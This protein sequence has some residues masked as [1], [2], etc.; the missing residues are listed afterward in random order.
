MKALE[1]LR[2]LN[3]EEFERL[4]RSAKRF[5]ETD[6]TEIGIPGAA[7]FELLTKLGLYGVARARVLGG[8][9]VLETALQQV[10]KELLLPSVRDMIVNHF[11][12]RAVLIKT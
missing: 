9:A 4:L 5:I 6:E 3:P 7:R 11:G 1:Q 10:R 12:R 8:G 2:L